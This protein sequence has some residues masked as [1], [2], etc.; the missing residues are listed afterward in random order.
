M[1]ATTARLLATFMVI[2]NG[3]AW[4]WWSRCERPGRNAQMQTRIDP[5]RLLGW[6]SDLLQ[7]TSL[8]YPVLVVVSPGWG[9][10][11]WFNWSS[12]IDFVLQ[13]VGIGLWAAGMSVVGWAAWTLGRY[14]AVSGL[15]VG[16]K[17]IMHGPYRRVR[18]PV[19][20]SFI[21]IAAGTALIFRSYLL[22][23]VAVA[24]MAATLWWTS[25]EEEVL[26]SSE[27]FGDAYRR[28]AERTGRF[29]PRLRRTQ[30][31]RS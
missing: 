19:Y 4:V 20:A 6:A 21:A 2:T 10:E 13:A 5:P 12:N 25:A 14:M 31:R 27:G 24:M 28:Y 8:V 11:A 15:V 16:H 3:V 7:V 23:A 17:L 1:D 29:L 30:G 26:A 22:V 18:H 9:Y